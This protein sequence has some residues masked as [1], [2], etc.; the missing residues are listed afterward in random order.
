[1]NPDILS[2][3]V[4]R[5]YGYAV[6]RT[7]SREEA[8]ELAQEILYTAVNSL[9]NLRDEDRFEPWLWALAANVTRSFRRNLGKERAIYSLPRTRQKVHSTGY[10]LQ[11]ILDNTEFVWYTWD[12]PALRKKN[13]N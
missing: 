6:S 1:M 3:Y 5:V 2:D 10:I 12:I 13:G 4:D 8:D 9:Q 11:K 7:Y